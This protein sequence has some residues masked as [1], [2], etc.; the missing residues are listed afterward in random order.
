MISARWMVI[1]VGVAVSSCAK[2]S[3]TQRRLEAEFR[4]FQRLRFD[5][6]TTILV[7]MH[8]SVNESVTGFWSGV[9]EVGGLVET[10]RGDTLIVV[11]HY[12]LKARTASSGDSRVDRVNDM[13]ILPD[14]VFIPAGSGLHFVPPNDGR[15]SGPN[16]TFIIVFALVAFDLYRRWPGH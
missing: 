15:R 12:I 10:V 8:S 7:V 6:A 5:S 9:L 11:P 14:L 16:W 3:M 13:R 4:S 1:V 2:T